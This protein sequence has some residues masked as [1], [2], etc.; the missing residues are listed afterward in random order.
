LQASL[1][2]IFGLLPNFQFIE[3]MQCLVNSH[4]ETPNALEGYGLDPRM[5][6]LLA[7]LHLKTDDNEL[8]RAQFSS[9]RSNVP[10]LY[11]ILIINTLAISITSLQVDQ[12][13]KTLFVPLIISTFA[14]VRAIWW[15]RQTEPN[16]LSNAQISTYLKRTCILAVVQTILFTVWVI[17]V[18][19]GADAFTRSNLTFFLALSQVSTVFC[20]MTL[21]VAAMLVALVSTVSFVLYFS[22]VDD[23]KLLPQALVLGCVCIGMAIVTHGFNRSFYEVVQSRRA[24][25]LRQEE[26]ARL[27]EENRRIAFT[28]PLTGLPNRRAIFAIAEEAIADENNPSPWLGLLDLDNFK[29][30]NDTYGHSAGDRVL[31][32]VA[33]Q[34]AND[35]KVLHAGR[36]GGDEFA[37]I[38]DGNE[39]ADS[40][41]EISENLAQSISNPL[42]VNG[43]NL[44]PRGSIGLRKTER[45]TLSE[46][47][48]RADFALFKAKE[49]EASVVLF[50]AEQERELLSRNSV[51]TDFQSAE[52]DRDLGL[53]FQPIIDFDTGRVVS[54]EALAR[55]KRDKMTVVMPDIFI[56]LAESSG[57]IGE[58][59]DEVIQ[60][61]VGFASS[62]PDD[63]SLQINLSSQDLLRSDLAAHVA[64]VMAKTKFA[65]EK[66]TFEITETVAVMN[67]AK[68][69]A[70]I[71]QLKGLGCKIALDDFGTGYSSLAYL[72]RYKF[73]QIKLDREFARKLTKDSPSAAVTS[74]V[75]SLC[76]RLGASCTIEGIE[77]REQALMARHLGMRRMQGYYFSKPVCQ[78]DLMDRILNGKTTTTLRR[79]RS[80]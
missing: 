67:E 50:D 2:S 72:E 52:F 23:W 12:L 78:A 29:Q 80:G 60:K 45:L 30:I 75:F 5:Q 44:H 35:V 55:W 76:Q 31:Q 28:D 42:V 59:T 46:C 57:R 70:T 47:L 79:S 27:N 63:I 62:W 48:E 74:T 41:I 22:W 24:L 32:R 61:A 20:L 64:A 26:T 25:R 56:D 13:S 71:S 38:L 16:K 43:L 6:E 21:R 14:L 18:Y 49:S 66:V 73:D 3:F 9:F 40:A 65:P 77:T 36:I 37:F 4:L 15:F 69:S 54:V 51:A 39:E 34:I 33:E 8:L 68:S 17:W 11:A 19:Q 10:L 1:G 7:H 53:D 58:L